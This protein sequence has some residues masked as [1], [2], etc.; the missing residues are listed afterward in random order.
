MKK[1]III[2]PAHPLRGGI[3]ASSERLAQELQLYNHEVIIYSFSL[4][5][6]DFLFPGTTQYTSDAPPNHV[7][8]VAKINSIN[9]FNWL[10][11]GREISKMKPDIVVC[12]FWL[13]FM[14]PCLG[15]ILRMIKNNHFTKIIGLADN[16]IPHEKRL[17][18][19]AFARYW[20]R[21]CHAFIVM[22]RSVAVDIQQFTDNKNIQF[23]PHPIYDNY[24]A[25]VSKEIARKELALKKEVKYLLF[26]GFIR[27]YKGL[28]ILLEAL[29]DARLREKNVHLILAGEYYG[30]Q[31]QYEALIQQHDLTTRIAN[32]THFIPNDAIKYYFCAADLVVQPYKSA[33]Q[34][35][36][37]QLAYHFEKPMVV[38]NV[39]GLPEIVTHGKSGYVTAVSSKSIAD[40]VVDFFENDRAF[41]MTEA[42]KSEKTRFSWKNL[43]QEVISDKF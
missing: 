20:V 14:S 39:G 11:V 28:D 13:P 5:Y 2:S 36:I 31:A 6:P 9:P 1:I 21:A 19:R 22:S 15:T 24:G 35:G 34:S 10:W 32:F 43:V 37:S 3:A 38:T 23:V 41:T 40:A 26:F 7:T 27:D 16:I 29:A 8:I 42:V 4:Q 18:D 25:I 12:R 17:A 30:N 33:T